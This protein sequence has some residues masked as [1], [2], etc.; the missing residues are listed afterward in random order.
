MRRLVGWVAVG[1][2]I[3]SF[4]AGPT[5]SSLAR[6]TDRA[7][8]SSDLG[9]GILHPPTGLAASVVGSTVTL[10]WTA[11]VDAASATGYDILRSTTS[12]GPYARVATVTPASATTAT[13]TLPSPGRYAY[14]L[15]TVAGGAPWTSADS[16]EAIVAV[17]TDTGFRS[18]GGQAAVAVAG[19]GDGY[20]RNAAE[21]C[22]TDGR[23]A[24]DRNSGTTR[25]DA[26]DD[27]GK[28][29]HDFRSFGLG[30]PAAASIDGIEV[31]GTWR[32]DANGGSPSVCVRLS[33]DGGASWTGWRQQA[34]T[35][36]AAAYV[37]GSSADAWGR[38]WAGGELADAT[39]R[40]EVVDVST[41]PNRDFRLDALQVRVTYTP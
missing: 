16:G 34:I 35:N 28:D 29:R 40:V 39:F 21:A 17:P 13:D 19:D 1:V 27:P 33:S 41:N 12:G 32:A 23:F 37:L 2:A 4:A 3:A 18:C 24:V 26:C 7:S 9:A 8:A 36:K 20:D 25:V 15:R 6:F 38:P 14:V 22:D 10:T 5:A 30:V 31:S 11:S